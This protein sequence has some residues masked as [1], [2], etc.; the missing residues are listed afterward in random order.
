VSVL[1]C[2]AALVRPM[3]SVE[4]HPTANMGQVGSSVIFARRHLPDTLPAP[5]TARFQCG[6]TAG[7]DRAVRSPPRAVAAIA[8]RAIHREGVAC[9]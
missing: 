2:R 4:K 8:R 6:F 5:H 7:A 9:M 3:G 1:A